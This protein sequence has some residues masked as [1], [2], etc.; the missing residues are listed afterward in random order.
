MQRLL[1]TLPAPVR[2]V[3]ALEPGESF[4]FE[5]ALLS[6]PRGIG[7]TLETIPAGRPTFIRSPPPPPN[8]RRGL[9]RTDFG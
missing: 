7:T 4:D 9:A 8:G 2:L 5:S 3:E 1:G 6:L